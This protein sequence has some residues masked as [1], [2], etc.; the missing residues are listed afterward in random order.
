MATLESRVDRNSPEYQENRAYF[1]GLVEELRQRI[2]QARQG[3]GERAI[4]KHRSRNKLLARERVELLSFPSAHASC[5]DGIGG[6]T[7]QW[8]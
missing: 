7:R 1:T 8:R 4:V 3:G 2:E 5:R 6:G